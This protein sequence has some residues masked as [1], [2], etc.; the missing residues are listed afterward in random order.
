MSNDLP[1]IFPK[2]PPTEVGSVFTSHRSANEEHW[3]TFSWRVPKTTSR[4][5]WT[6]FSM[7]VIRMNDMFTSCRVCLETIRT[8]F[9]VKQLQTQ[10]VAFN[11]N[12]LIYFI[13]NKMF[14]IGSLCKTFSRLRVLPR[15]F[16][17]F[18]LMAAVVRRLVTCSI[19]GLQLAS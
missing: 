19:T 10:C 13:Y 9:H 2:I 5:V 14:K 7:W 1:L 4:A 12:C 17:H 18:T 15:A 3:T 6:V 8:H 11:G 16:Y